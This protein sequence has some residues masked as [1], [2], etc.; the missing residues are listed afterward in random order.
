MLFRNIKVKLRNETELTTA[1]RCKA[2][3]FKFQLEEKRDKR[4]FVDHVRTKVG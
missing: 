4:D 2:R 1:K 3:N